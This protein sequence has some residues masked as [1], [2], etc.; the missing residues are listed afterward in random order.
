MLNIIN[1]SI[2]ILLVNIAFED[3]Q[4]YQVSTLKLIV[5][6]I[7]N[8]SKTYF[9]HF[10]IRIILPSLRFL[11][12]LLIALLI[13]CYIEYKTNRLLLGAGDW[14]LLAGLSLGYDI[15]NTIQ[16]ILILSLLIIATGL[17]IL[18]VNHLVYKKYLRNK[19]VEKKKQIS[20][21]LAP[22]FLVTYLIL[23]L[24]S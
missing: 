18:I 12:A 15:F 11:V 7:L 22:L 10:N 14:F 5:N 9:S 23:R 16:F 2:F 1:F 13:T 17:T 24:S 21:P 8:F 4:S 19:K 3:L 20:F 6:L